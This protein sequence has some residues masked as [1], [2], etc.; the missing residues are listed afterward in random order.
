MVAKV[1]K[2]DSQK[3]A[4]QSPTSVHLFSEHFSVLNALSFV[5]E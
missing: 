1:L 3:G 4:C 5:V 2:S